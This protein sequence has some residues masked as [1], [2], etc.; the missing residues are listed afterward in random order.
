MDIS[1]NLHLT[2]V[3]LG[4]NGKAS[5]G[6]IY[7]N[8]VLRCGD[9][10]DEKRKEKVAG[11]TRVPNCIA[12]LGLRREGGYNT[13]YLKKYGEGFH[14]GMICVYNSPDW[15]L[16]LESMSFQYVLFHTGNTEK[17][18]AACCLPNYV[19][20]FQKF[21]GSRSA[22]AYKSIYPEI[23]QAIIDWEE[24]RASQPTIAYID[25]ETGK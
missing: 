18:T 19:L 2:I 8:G 5:L 11:E 21:T 9:V 16:I 17:H 6:A 1:D 12:F 24:G 22:D 14:K 23:A 4:D 13:K 7:I 20:D 10:A 15:K 25:I 3:R